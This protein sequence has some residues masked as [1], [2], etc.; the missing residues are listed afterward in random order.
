MITG[1]KNF[2]IEA[3]DNNNQKRLVE[4]LKFVFRKKPTPSTNFP[5]LLL[6][7]LEEKGNK[8]ARISGQS[9]ECSDCPLIDIE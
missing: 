5:L 3:K 1:K 2:Q 8:T 6:R 4:K 9:P 7:K